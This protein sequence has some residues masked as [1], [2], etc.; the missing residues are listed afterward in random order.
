MILDS[1]GPL[2]FWIL[3]TFFGRGKGNLKLVLKLWTIILQTTHQGKMMTFTRDRGGLDTQD[4]TLELIK[5][6]CHHFPELLFRLNTVKALIASYTLH[7]INPWQ[8]NTV[9]LKVFWKW[10]C[11]GT[12]AEH[13]WHRECL[14]SAEL[15]TH[16]ACQGPRTLGFVWNKLR[17]HSQGFYE[18]PTVYPSPQPQEERYSWKHRSMLMQWL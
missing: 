13:G 8:A 3:Q 15:K 18:P 7:S 5:H 16:W 2:Q 6:Q 4:S 9:S 14:C 17:E 11:W 1:Q 12:A 10:T